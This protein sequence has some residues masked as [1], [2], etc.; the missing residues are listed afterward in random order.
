MDDLLEADFWTASKCA[1][2]CRTRSAVT[3]AEAAFAIATSPSVNTSRLKGSD[4]VQECIGD[5][6]RAGVRVQRLGNGNLAREN[7]N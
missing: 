7:I 4:P 3:Q 5:L 6:P 1:I 2:K